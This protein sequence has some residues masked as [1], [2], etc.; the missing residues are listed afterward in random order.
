MC[1]I[2][3]IIGKRSSRS[4]K[5]IIEKLLHRG[6]DSNNFWISDEGE[7]PVTIC[8]TRLS[9]IDL[10]D[11]GSQ[12]FFS[13]DRRYVLVFNGEIYNYIELKK[14]LQKKGCLF[15]TR[16]D[17]EVLLKGLI[18]EGPEFQLRCNGMWAFCL[19]DRKLNKAL[20]GRDRFGIK[21]LYYY[22][23]EG[24]FIF[25][26]EMK[27]ITP[28]IKKFET[29]NNIDSLTKSIFNYESTEECVIK[30]I[31]R[32]KAGHYLIF[33]NKN[34]IIK[35]YWNT[36]DH[37]EFANNK[38]EEQ[39]EEWKYLF[40]D[41][42]RLRMRSDVA[43][44]SA[45]SGGLDSS[46]VVAAMN[47]ISNQN[48]KK[49]FCDD[50]QHVFCSSFPGSI[51]DETKWAEKVADNLSLTLNKLIYKPSSYPFSLEESMAMVE[52]PY[53]TLPLPM[54]FTYREIKKNGINVTLDGHGSDELFSGYGHIKKAISLRINRERIKELIA[55]EDSLNSGIFSPNEKKL[56]R[57]WV[58]YTLQ[59]IIQDGLF[60]SYKRL[61]NLPG[62]LFNRFRLS[63][64]YFDHELH[65]HPVYI[66]M[67]SFN[68]VLFDL[69]H[70]SFLP[71]LL[72][73]YDKYS[74]ASGVEVRM[75]FMD[76]RLVCNSF[77]LPTESKLGGTFTKRIQRDSLKKILLDDIRLRRD[78]IGWNAPSHDWFKNFLKSEIDAILRNNKNSKYFNKSCK[79][80]NYFH[81]IKKPTFEDGHKT[82]MIL[83]PL[84][85]EN[86]L[87]N[88]IWK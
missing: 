47:Y 41:S 75:P 30:G 87:N 6:P 78:K 80:W 50:W 21:P 44:G 33:D 46:S 38:Y 68:Q 34:I 14:E 72:R 17:T 45:L 61:C 12:P 62:N 7:C 18:F 26:S 13:D 65:K 55:I 36:L 48:E 69:F 23:K 85:W 31:K 66:E 86:S 15:K 64:S 74:M 57:K 71:T 54:L 9:I 19:W 16:T 39:V 56:K 51:N 67:D 88:N 10:S 4:A 59:N 82:W 1:G 43:I 84:I 83:L 37:I 8:H 35:R 40:L 70:H 2:G 27:S 29:S 32:L 42:V 25:G 58:K 11:D 73:N 49:S 5:K 60:D 81:N 77:S 20:F 79:E 52:D 28:F 76:W 63:P 22:Q 24:L 53:L 3:G